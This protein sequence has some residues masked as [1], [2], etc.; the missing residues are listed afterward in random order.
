MSFQDFQK[1]VGECAA[2]ANQIHQNA[3]A[4][5]QDVYVGQYVGKLTEATGDTFSVKEDYTCPNGIEVSTE[6]KWPLVRATWQIVS[7][8]TDQTLIGRTVSKTFY[9]N[10]SKKTGE[11]MDSQTVKGMEKSLFGKASEKLGETLTRVF[12][13]GLHTNWNL[14][15]VAG[16]G[17]YSDRINLY[18]NNHVK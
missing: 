12:T 9:F 14:S 15:G 7:C 17:E 2:A 1:L 18:V 10:P 5:K 3:M 16:K 6:D 8:P 11:C 13:E 4:G